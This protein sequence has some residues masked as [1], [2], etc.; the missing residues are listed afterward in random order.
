MKT[1]NTLTMALGLT[2]SALVSNANAFDISLREKGPC[3]S[4]PCTETCKYVLDLSGAGKNAKMTVQTKYTRS[5]DG[6]VEAQALFNVPGYYAAEEVV[7]FN[8]GSSTINESY[9]NHR[10]V[11]QDEGGA[12]NSEDRWGTIVFNGE[13]GEVHVIR[14]DKAED[15]D[16]AAKKSPSQAADLM[17]QKAFFVSQSS[18][19][20]GS[21]SWVRDFRAAAPTRR[22]DYDVKRL[23][24]DSV[25]PAFY[26]FLALRY[27]PAASAQKV[28]MFTL[29]KNKNTGVGEFSAKP[30]GTAV[31]WTGKI[32][33]D[34]GSL[35]I[36][37]T[38]NS[39]T[40]QLEQLEFKIN[41]IKTLEGK[42]ASQSCT[43]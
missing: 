21:A 26:G 6:R 11:G 41:A 36:N 40:G 14:A 43:K 12:G 13:L 24:P 33:I 39:T 5:A 9:V 25:S 7:V 31:V 23:T 32:A 2:L 1:K 29:H 15:F 27:A 8:P 38:V 17:K 18:L 3:G 16:D 19:P 30:T 10:S 20:I 35:N 42:L 37:P 28:P 4:A 34:G 22:P